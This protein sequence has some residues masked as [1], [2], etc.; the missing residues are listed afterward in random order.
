MSGG[1]GS[2]PT[3][4]E[5]A[6]EESGVGGEG[7]ESGGEK[8]G[9]GGASAVEDQSGAS[10]V[11]DGLAVESGQSSDDGD[12]EESASQMADLSEKT[13]DLREWFLLDG[14][15]LGIA[16]ILLVALV[17][18]LGVAERV[19][20]IPMADSQP[21]F[22]VLSSLISG[23]LTLITVVVSINQLLLSREM[24]SPGELESQ[25]QNVIEYR[26]DVEGHA[27]E[28]APVKP[29]G[30][31][32]LL[33]SN[34]RQEAQRIGGMTFGAVGEE[35]R[36]EVDDTVEALTE[37]ADHVEE[38]LD[39]SDA[40]T[41]RVLSVTLTTNYAQQINEIRRIRAIHGEE[42][43]E[44][45]MDA[46]DNLIEHLQK[47]DIA[48][49]YFK[50]LYLQEE[51]SSLSRVLLYAGFPA[52][53]FLVLMLLGFTAEEPT[54]VTQHSSL[55]IPVIVG[56]AFTPLALLFAFIVRI[57]TVTERTAATIPFTTPKQE[58]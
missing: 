6:D 45:V 28:I 20:W 17:G 24:S 18:L 40:N 53:A 34:T 2:D 7:S 30:F 13:T 9:V 21:M 48:R 11:K 12:H 14:N 1:P 23:N 32:E 55:L 16:A 35:I 50:S 19:G 43:P 51:L 44:T 27:G 52:E 8:S 4:E 33:F 58:Q 26:E 31:L 37:H 38:I 36:G 42:L 29:L 15:R 25:I 54:A 10:S 5:A 22:Y 47:V 3:S 56:I 49:Q 57:A 41:F 39:A 46:L